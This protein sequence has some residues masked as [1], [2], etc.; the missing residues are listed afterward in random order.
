MNSDQNSSSNEADV[1]RCDDRIVQCFLWATFI[2]GLVATTATA[3]TLFILVRPE[4]LVPEFAFGRIRPIHL[5]ILV[6]AFAANG[7]FAAMYFSTQKLCK[8]SM[9]SGILSYL[10]FFGWQFVNVWALTTLLTD[11]SQH[12]NSAE[13]VWQ[14]DVGIAI[15]MALFAVNFLMT[16][17]VRRQ[18]HMYISIWFYMASVIAVLPIHILSNLVVPGEGYSSTSF[19]SGVQD[20]FVQSW[21]GQNLLYY[22]L[23]MPA[24]GVMYYF[25][26]RISGRPVAN[27]RLA[28]VQFWLMTLLGVF[29]GARLLHF[30]AAPEWLSSLG[31]LAG[32][33][34]FLPC[35]VGV[36]NGLAM[37]GGPI[38]G[39]R[40]NPILRFFV[41]AILFFAF[42]SV[43]A[44]LSSIKSISVL[45]IFTDWTTAHTYA[46][47]FGWAG[48]LS[49]GAAYWMMTQMSH[50]PL[51]QPALMKWHHW[52]ATAGAFLL[53]ASTYLSGFFQGSMN[54]SLDPTG[55]LVYP[56]FIEILQRVE[57]LWHVAFVGA[58]LSGFAM[59]MFGVNLG[60]IWLFRD[61]T[62]R[63]I[64]ALAPRL[65][66]DFEC[67][68]TPGSRL[69]NAA[70]LGLGVKLDVWSKLVWHRRLER[71]TFTFA[72]LIVLVLAIGFVVEYVP[73]LAFGRVLPDADQA[74]PYTP[75]EL[76]GRAIYVREGCASCHT[77]TVRPLVPE[78]KRYGDFS[79]AADFYFDR[80][81]QWGTQRIG[82]D[83][84]QE[85]GRRNGYWHWQHL[86]DPGTTSPG[87]IMPSFSHLHETEIDVEEIRQMLRDEAALGVPYDEQLL[88]DDE[89]TPEDRLFG[90]VTE[91]ESAIQD[92]AEVI[93]ADIV[94]GGGPA[95]RL[96]QEATAL[97]AYLQRLGSLPEPQSGE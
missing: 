27:Y 17:C 72:I 73:I 69:E 62:Q 49:M 28:I 37:L 31:M 87:S 82:P 32:V 80:P 11:H 76:A 29:A 3:A 61:R 75:L 93:A 22:M 67:E 5:T 83:L 84:A 18:R 42:V 71:S 51:W 24:M 77:Q 16:L 20:G 25:V 55:I 38:N 53:I 52:I 68:P 86:F 26:P 50:R 12:R 59:L 45:T 88:A 13:L 1:Y 2:W 92:Q 60:A 89:L 30:T 94:I 95:A 34:V 74:V 65:A 44:G 15:V 6:Y 79:R 7:L 64:T 41:I 21:G 10:H 57:P 54:R 47:A 9:W 48:F 70:I 81:T 91:L 90:D 46:V 63:K 36:T 78:S 14:V 85:G 23:V 4:L 19:Y 33:L 8:C 66:S 58:C 96:N 56:E 97:I 40:E 35:W 43:E 39:F